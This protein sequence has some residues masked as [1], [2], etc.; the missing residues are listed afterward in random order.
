MW[1][2]IKSLILLHSFISL[3]YKERTTISDHMSDFQDVPWIRCYERVSNLMMRF[4]N[5]LYCFLYWSL[6]RHFS[7]LQR[8]HL[9]KVMFLSKWLRVL[10]LM[11]IWKGRH[12]VL[13]ENLMIFSQ[14]IELWCQLKA[15]KT[16]EMRDELFFKNA[17]LSKH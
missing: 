11:R 13:H 14:E 15:G 5:C 12:M 4:S 17:F 9:L 2:K 10:F 16:P 7:F 6:W 3:K 1:E 8:I